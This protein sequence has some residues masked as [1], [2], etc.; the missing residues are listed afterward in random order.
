MELGKSQMFHVFKNLLVTFILICMMISCD[1]EGKKDCAWFLEPE[2]KLKNNVVQGYIPVCARNRK[3]MKQDCRLQ[4][5]LDKAKKYYGKVFRYND[6]SVE[7][8]AIPR[9]ITTIKFCHM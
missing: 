2:P 7:S 6:M 9:T 8:V 4:T 3:T 1:P 5:T